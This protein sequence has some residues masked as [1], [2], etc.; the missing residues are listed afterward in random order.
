MLSLPRSFK[1]A[2]HGTSKCR[3]TVRRV[4]TPSSVTTLTLIKRML[5]VLTTG[6]FIPQYRRIG[7]RRDC[8][9]LSGWYLFYNNIAATQHV[10]VALTYILFMGVDAEPV[11]HHLQTTGD[12]LN[13]AQF[14]AVCG[15]HLIL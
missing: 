5:V 7:Q 15:G 8:A 14:I 13:L 2:Q 1:L 3:E 10:S 11:E 6:S 12:W 9:G 4:I